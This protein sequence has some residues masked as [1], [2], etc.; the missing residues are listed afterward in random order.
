M[1][2]N[3]STNTSNPI[4]VSQG[5]SGDSS[6]TAYAVVCG[7]TTSTGALQSVSGVGSAAQVL[8]SNGSSALPTWQNPASNSWI[9][10]NTQ[11]A[12]SS[13]SLT[14]SST[15][16]TSTYSSY[17]VVFTNIVN[18]STSGLQMQW[19]T[20]NGSTYLSTSYQSGVQYNTY[21]S[22]TFNNASSTSICVLSSTA[23]NASSTFN[24]TCYLFLPTSAAAAFNGQMFWQGTVTANGLV[25]GTNSGTTT[26]NNIQFLFGT[27]NITSGTISLY[28]L[29]Q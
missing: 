22:N 24:G 20:N 12:S 23:V 28:G 5:G 27:G 3:N 7:G 1:A 18:A 4:T 15:Y 17:A 25:F 13:A 16:I 21:N 10:L 26:I 11:T 8:T 29:G 2:T 14:F 6:L 9:L 19:S